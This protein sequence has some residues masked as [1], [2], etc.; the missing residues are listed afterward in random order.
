MTPNR[1]KVINTALVALL[2][3]VAVLYVAR[4]RSPNGGG[5]AIAAS[6]LLGSLIIA[7][8]VAANGKWP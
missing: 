3:M 7:A 5:Y 8:A 4:F 1:Q 6:I 2:I